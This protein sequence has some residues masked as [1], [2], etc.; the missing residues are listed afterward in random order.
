MQARQELTSK[1]VALVK[2]WWKIECLG[3]DHVWNPASSRVNKRKGRKVANTDECD[4]CIDCSACLAYCFCSHKPMGEIN[5]C[6]M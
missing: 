5:D 4:I 3:K 2:Q 6:P 1:A